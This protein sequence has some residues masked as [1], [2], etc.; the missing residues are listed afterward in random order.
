[1]CKGRIGIRPAQRLRHRSAHWPVTDRDPGRDGTIR[2]SQFLHLALAHF[3]QRQIMK[4]LPCGSKEGSCMTMSLETSLVRTCLLAVLVAVSVGPARAETARA[5]FGA[6]A[7]V[8]AVNQPG[9]SAALPLP[10]PGHLLQDDARGR[11]YVFEGAIDS[12]RDYYRVQMET[13]GY[14]LVAETALDA[15]AV[16]MHFRRDH[17]LTLVS[18]RAAIG[19]AP[20]RIGLRAM[21][22]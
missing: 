18:L 20:T 12:A 19:S 7:R 21:R 3:R 11:H 1:M 8:L 17:E 15:N 13:L 14:E 9:L 10:V 2:A 6:S 16:E 5:N 4:S 22:R